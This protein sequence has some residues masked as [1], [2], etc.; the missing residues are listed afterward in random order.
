MELT[1]R[2]DRH[3][4][5]FL[6]RCTGCRKKRSLRTNSFFAEFPKIPLGT[7]LRVM[8]SFVHEESQR[9]IAETLNLR[10]SLVSR[11]YRR[12]QDLCSVDLENRSFLPF[13]GPG[14]ILKCDESKFNHKAKYNRGRSA[15]RDA[16][17]FGI[18][19][20]EHSPARGYFKVVDRRNAAT[21]LPI[22]N[23]CVLP[24]SEIHTDDW[25]AYRRLLQVPN[26]RRH[27]VVVHAHNFVDPRTGVHTQE[28]E[29]CW[30]QLK[31]GQ[32]QRKGLRREDLQSYLDERMW[33]QWRGGDHTQI[34][35]N[36]IT[37][38]PLQFSTNHPAL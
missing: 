5:G 18:V 1:E 14:A 10:R 15:A 13:G 20:T 31:L 29:S 17:V 25:G 32:K 12:L 16:W 6:W 21:L 4:D 30:N 7:L 3:V 27:R 2:N 38:I 19:T 34:M 37:I 36:F 35:E 28:V 24:G 26:V 23:R 9:R 11:I 8:F 33:R 22:I